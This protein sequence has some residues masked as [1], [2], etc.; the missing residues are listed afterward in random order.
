MSITGGRIGRDEGEAIAGKIKYVIDSATFKQGKY[1]PAT[2]IRIVSPASLEQ[3]PVEAVIIM[4]ASY[5]DEIVKIMQKKYSSKIK[6]AILREEG[7]EEL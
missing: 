7:L 4:A 2:H 3:D 6:K 5:S 1:T